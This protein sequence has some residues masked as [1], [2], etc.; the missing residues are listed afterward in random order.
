MT[1]PDRPLTVAAVDDHP[2][3]LR[4]IESAL[5]DHAPWVTVVRQ[6]PS[7]TALLHGSGRPAE[8]VLLDLHLQADADRDPGDNVR[9][10]R[11]RGASVIVLTAESRPV[12][13]REAVAAGAA[14]V[15]LKADPVETLVAAL[16]AV[17]AGELATSSALAHALVTDD[18]LAGELTTREREVFDLLAHGVGRSEIG[19]LLS[20]PVTVHAVDACV[21]RVAQRYRALGRPTF[22]AYETLTQLVHDG[23]LDLYAGPPPRP[24][25]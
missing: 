15:C 7:V 11:A 3:V 2:F 9:R 10:L 20:P 14:G 18:R 16:R 12:P 8:I 23:H 6:A 13:I 5:A 24:S 25:D 17:R 22:N 1:G 4:G 21:K 19:K